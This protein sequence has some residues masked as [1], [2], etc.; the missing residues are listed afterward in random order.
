ML[1]LAVTLNSPKVVPLIR[2]NAH[3]LPQGSMSILLLLL[4][5]DC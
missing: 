5:T 4:D 2:M 3:Y 1:E